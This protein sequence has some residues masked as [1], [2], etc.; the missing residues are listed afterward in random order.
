M[1]VTIRFSNLFCLATCSSVMLLIGWDIGA[2]W[3]HTAIAVTDHE[4]T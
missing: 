4:K 1:N 3:G 2:R